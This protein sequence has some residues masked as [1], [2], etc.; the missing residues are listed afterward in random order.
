MS[1]YLHDIPLP[2]AQARLQEALEA[3]GLWQILGVEEIP[4]DENALGRVLAEPVWARLSSPHYHASAMD[5]FALRAEKTTGALPSRPVVLRI[6]EEAVY[7]DTGDPLPDWANAVVPIENIEPVD[8]EGQLSPDPR[9][10]YAI[11]LRDALPPWTHVRPMGEDIV[12]TELVLPAGHTLRPVDLGAVAASGHAVLRVARRPRVA[13]L[14]TGTELVPIGR[15]VK[16]G[17]SSNT[18]LWSWPPRCAP[19]VGSRFA[20]PSPAMIFPT[21]VTTSPGRP[22]TATW[23]CSTPV[24]PPVRRIFPPAWSRNSA[25]CSST[26]SPSD[27]AIR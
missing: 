5:G 7:V 8:A 15:P 9:H 20:F 27:R 22:R 17:E 13:I 3:A 6:D 18:I 12:A 10:P 11:R 14:P 1:I 2:Q 21:S 16:K 19:G 23:C 26:A 25:S 4:L 24:R